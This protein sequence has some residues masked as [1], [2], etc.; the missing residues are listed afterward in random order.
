MSCSFPFSLLL[1]SIFPLW[2]SSVFEHNINLLTS[3]LYSS[4]NSPAALTSPTSTF[5]ASPLSLDTVAHND[6][7]RNPLF[8]FSWRDPN[9]FGQERHCCLWWNCFCWAVSQKNNNICTLGATH[10]HKGTGYTETS[11]PVNCFFQHRGGVRPPKRCL[12]R[13]P[14]SK[15]LH[16]EYTQ[17]TCAFRAQGS[18]VVTE[19]FRGLCEGKHSLCKVILNKTVWQAALS[20]LDSG[21]SSTLWDAKEKI[22][23]WTQIC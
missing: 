21:W 19:T 7:Q 11:C 2:Q 5:F 3:T 10:T 22:Q 13:K 15:L 1:F 20:G 12:T 6:P 14:T 17:N 23:S 18:S 9:C 16:G 8:C 4:C